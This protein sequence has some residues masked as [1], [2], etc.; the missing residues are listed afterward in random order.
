MP[1]WLSR[2]WFD[3]RAHKE[4]E[5]DGERKRGRAFHP[6]PSLFLTLKTRCVSIREARDKS[7]MELETALVNENFSGPQT[8]PRSAPGGR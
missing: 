7:R 6:V 3:I 5:S 2:S 4:R 1:A 8:A